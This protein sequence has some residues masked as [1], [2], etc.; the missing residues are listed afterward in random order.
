MNLNHGGKPS[1]VVSCDCRR[2]P[3]PLVQHRGEQTLFKDEAIL[4][5]TQTL[6]GTPKKMLASLPS[7]EEPKVL[8]GIIK[9]KGAGGGH[10][11]AHVLGID[12]HR[13]PFIRTGPPPFYRCRN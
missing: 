10:L 1:T 5:D 2:P 4:Q 13:F 12:L 3:E 11:L 8:K 6:N 9:K 7:L